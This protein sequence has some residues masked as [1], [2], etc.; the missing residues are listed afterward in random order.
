VT[1]YEV[2]INRLRII[3]CVEKPLFLNQVGSFCDSGY[4][5]V[6]LHVE[7]DTECHDTKTC[8][9]KFL[10]CLLWLLGQTL[11]GF[12]IA[13]LRA[14]MLP[15][16]CS[17]IPNLDIG[18]YVSVSII[19]CKLIVMQISYL[20]IPQLMVS[21]CEKI[22]FDLFENRDCQV[23]VWLCKVAQ[24]GAIMQILKIISSDT[25]VDLMTKNLHQCRR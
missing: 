14:N 2:D 23:P 22:K 1:Y 7:K 10:C 24:S 17:W 12:E 16:L 15:F 19:F 6:V 25:C 4:L 13:E 5:V 8:K 11:F 9:D 18:C 21:D 3:Y 20:C